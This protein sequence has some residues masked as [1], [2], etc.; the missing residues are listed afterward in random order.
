VE[1]MVYTK[2]TD[3]NEIHLWK[4][5]RQQESTRSGEELPPLVYDGRRGLDNNDFDNVVEAYFLA[6]TLIAT[7]TFAAT[8]TM[9]GG[10]DQTK[11]IAIHGHN[12]AFKIFVV[13]NTVA[14]CSSIVVIFLL[15]WARQEPVILRL[16]YLMWSQTLTIIACLTMLLSLMTTVYITVAPTAPWAAYSVIAIGVGSPALFL[17]ISRMGRRIFK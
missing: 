9:P 10:Y 17:F 15:I 8:F 13:S 2:P 6:A 12:S 5:L 3:T 11:G 7:V 4:Q 1:K 16:H 14:M